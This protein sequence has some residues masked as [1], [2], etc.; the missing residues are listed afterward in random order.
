MLP[1][2]IANTKF[3]NA[4]RIASEN[5]APG[6]TRCQNTTALSAEP[7][8]LPLIPSPP[9]LPLPPT[10]APSLK[11]I[12]ISMKHA[13]AP[14][15]G[16]ASSSSLL[17]LR[18][19]L[20]TLPERF[21][22][23]V[24]LAEAVRPKSMPADSDVQLGAPVMPNVNAI[25]SGTCSTVRP[26][27]GSTSFASSMAA[28][29]EVGLSRVLSWLFFRSKRSM[30]KLAEGVEV[31]PA[32][33]IVRFLSCVCNVPQVRQQRKHAKRAESPLPS[34]TAKFDYRSQRS[35]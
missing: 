32:D 10:F 2:S 35:R 24:Q 34:C 5:S 16:S 20:H 6:A 9:T 11:S 12:P 17:K 31:A 27:N 23:T 21:T 13:P 8:A 33:M 4:E 1:A 22:L 25:S 7:C 3:S 30:T 19:T 28:L 26:A 18:R 29:A 15:V 14:F